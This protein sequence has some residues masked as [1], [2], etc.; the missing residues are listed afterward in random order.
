LDVLLTGPR[1]PGVTVVAAKGLT[2]E[3]VGYPPDD[4]LAARAER[5]RAV[6]TRT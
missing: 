6:R 1:D 5:A 4:D 2:L 3:E